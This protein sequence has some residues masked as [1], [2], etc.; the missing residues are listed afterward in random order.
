[1]KKRAVAWLVRYE[2][3]IGGRWR[4][5]S[6]FRVHTKSQVQ[7]ETGGMRGLSLY[8][9]VSRPIALVPRED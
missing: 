4:K 3:Y 9:N 7:H 8:R 2:H 1:M 6:L 5:E